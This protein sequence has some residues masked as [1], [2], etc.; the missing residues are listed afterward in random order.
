MFEKIAFDVRIG[1]IKRKE[2]YD[3]EWDAV[4][5][6]ISSEHKNMIFEYSGKVDARNA[7]G[8]LNRLIRDERLPIDVHVYKINKVLVERKIEGET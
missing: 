5:Q 7:A 4:H 8:W 2:K 6:F 1:A 3:A